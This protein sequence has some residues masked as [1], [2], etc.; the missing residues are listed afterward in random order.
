MK[1]EVGKQLSFIVWFLYMTNDMY[2]QFGHNRQN[3]F[4]LSLVFALEHD[5]RREWHRREARG[6]K[7]NEH[8]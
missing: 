5:G 1:L 6:G 3:A 4:V 2:V 7:V 8:N